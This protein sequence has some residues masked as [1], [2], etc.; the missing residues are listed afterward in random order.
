MGCLR[1]KTNESNYKE[2]DRRLKEQFI[3]GINDEMMTEIIGELT[4]IRKQENHQ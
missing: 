3:N 4:I 2:K 1:M